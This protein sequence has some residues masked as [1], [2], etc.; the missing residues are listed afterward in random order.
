M[1]VRVKEDFI[2]LFCAGEGEEW[3]SKAK[4]PTSILS[5][6]S[7]ILHQRE[8]ILACRCWILG[9]PGSSSRMVQMEVRMLSM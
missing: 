4:C 2:F 3:E 5:V 7:A 8:G 1:E 9:L 6:I